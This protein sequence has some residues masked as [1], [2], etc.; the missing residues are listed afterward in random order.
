LV[1]T[2]LTDEQSVGH[3][4]GWGHYLDRLEAAARTGDAG[5]DD[6]AAAP[7]PMDE[8]SAAEASLAVCQLTLRGLTE[9]DMTSSTPCAKFTVSD[10]LDHLLGS[11]STLGA[12]AG[13]PEGIP[14]SA[15]AEVRVANAAQ[16]ALEAW[17]RRGLDGEVQIGGGNLPAARA[18]SILSLEFLVHA[19]DFA[20]VTSERPQVSEALSD[21]V[22]GLTTGLIAPPMR[23][24][25]R[26]GAE[27]D[28]GLDAGNLE[29][30]VAFT[31]R[32][33]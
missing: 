17:R 8:L 21:Y 2:G 26:F 13:G 31:G 10:L 11:I 3:A 4:G 30:L 16:P 19:W 32:A 6:W 7:D 27:L 29:R 23:D 33:V 15:P 20:Q 18:A 22:L 24:G 14:T 5:A 25:D 12:A 28:A 9:A 1:H